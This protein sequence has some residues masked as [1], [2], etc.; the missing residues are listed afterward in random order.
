MIDLYEKFKTSNIKIE[1]YQHHA[2]YTNDDAVKV[3]EKLGFT[4][5]ETKSLFLQNKHQQYFVYLTYTTKRTDFKQLKKLIGQRL[6]IVPSQK[7]EELTQQ[8]PGAV[9]PFGYDAAIPLI[10]DSDL[11]RE[12]KLVFAPGRPDQTMVLP[13]SE[14]SKVTNLFGNKVYIFKEN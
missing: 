13:V 6:S 8:A 12:K 2:I 14:L 9:S 3:K 4:G 11:L 7:M 10:I 1:R 5:T